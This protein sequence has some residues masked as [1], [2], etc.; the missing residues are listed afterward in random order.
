M[1]NFTVV[2]DPYAAAEMHNFVQTM[3]DYHIVAITGLSE[4]CPVGF[5]LRDENGG[6]HLMG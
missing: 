6:G 1:S 2:F 5:F 4:W 3:V